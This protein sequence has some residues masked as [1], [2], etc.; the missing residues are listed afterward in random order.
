MTARVLPVVV[1]RGEP[2]AAAAASGLSPLPWDS[3]GESESAA[4][5]RVRAVAPGTARPGHDHDNDK[6]TRTLVARP[7][8]CCL[9]RA[10][11][12]LPAA[13]NRDPSGPHAQA[14]W[15]R[16]Q[17]DQVPSLLKIES[18]QILCTKIC[19]MCRKW[20]EQPIYTINSISAIFFQVL[21]AILH[22]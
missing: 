1:G 20:K 22:K 16:I 3:V 21:Y 5:G 19:N 7:C 10:A 13:G 15:T 9:L 4:A 8:R 6:L 2:A 14:Q 12:S 11:G 18:F 17:S